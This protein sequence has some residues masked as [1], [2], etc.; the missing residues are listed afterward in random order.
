MSRRKRNRQQKGMIV[1]RT[2]IAGLLASVLAPA[3]AGAFPADAAT[4]DADGFLYAYSEPGVPCRWS[5]NAP[6]WGDCA[7][8]VNAVFN[9]GYQSTY[10][11][12]NL[13][14]GSGYQGAWAC[15]GRGDTWFPL[16]SGQWIF[17][18][19]PGLRGYGESTY[20]NIASS[21]WVSRCGN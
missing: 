15:I 8:N 20:N 13:Y 17:S 1:W 11:K 3:F 12:V 4:S 18:W 9:N 5:T 16:D 19:G 14:W 6:D 2:S 10:D 21:K 7:N